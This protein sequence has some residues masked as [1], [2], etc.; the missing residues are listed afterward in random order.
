MGSYDHKGAAALFR[1]QSQEGHT[2][3]LPG[4]PCTPPHPL[5]G[6]ANWDLSG[7]EAHTEPHQ[8]GTPEVEGSQ[9]G[10]GRRSQAVPS[11]ARLTSGRPE[12]PE[13]A[14]ALS[15][16]HCGWDPQM[17]GPSWQP[18]TVHTHGCSG[19]SYLGPRPLGWDLLGR[20]S[21]KTISDILNYFKV[22]VFMK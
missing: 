9:G 1:L 4:Q 17:G 22:C 5:Q 21:L 8:Q 3:G 19:P 13:E 15:R 2:Q 11:C 10:V 20:A 14:G 7:E 18:V 16:L 6:R 12:G